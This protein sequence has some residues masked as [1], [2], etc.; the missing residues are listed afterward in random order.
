MDHPVTVLKSISA[1]PFGGLAVGLTPFDVM[2]V[3]FLFKSCSDPSRN[4][5][6]P[7]YHSIIIITPITLTSGRVILENQNSQ[8]SI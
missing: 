1:A 5:L 3:Y 2:P 8:L 4:P 6:F 7:S